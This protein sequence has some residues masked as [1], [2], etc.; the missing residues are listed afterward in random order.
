MTQAHRQSS[1]STN[2]L[3][4]EHAVP[5][6]LLFYLQ[7]LSTR[8][9][10]TSHYQPIS[11]FT[12][13]ILHTSTVSTGTALGLHPSPSPT[14]PKKGRNN[15]QLPPPTSHQATSFL[16]HLHHVA[17]PLCNSTSLTISL[18]SLRH[19]YLVQIPQNSKSLLS[20]SL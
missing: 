1:G 10:S 14:P 16:Q 20:C 18:A 7:P 15:L 12:L 9:R 11:G 2:L 13:F 17:N 19:F 8:Q 5:S 6:I 4:P 3:V